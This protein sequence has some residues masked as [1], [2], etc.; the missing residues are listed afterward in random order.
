MLRDERDDGLDLGDVPGQMTHLKYFHEVARCSSIRVAAARL[1]VASSAIS[2]RIQ[3]IEAELGAA[4]FER[5][6][7]GVRLTEMG[8]VYARYARDSLMSLRRVRSELD[9]LR[10]LERGH[11][12]ILTIEGMVAEFLSRLITETR[13]DQP[14]ITFDLTITGADAVIAGIVNGDADIGVAFN[15]RP[16][17][18]VEAVAKWPDPV[19][20]VMAPGHA[21]ARREEVDLATVLAHPVAIAHTSFG[22]RYLLDAA[23][24]ELGLTLEPAL[25]TNSIEALRAFARRGSGTTLLHG[26][27]I[28]REIR[29]GSLIAVPVKAPALSSGSVDICVL[30]GRPLPIAASVF[31]ERLIARRPT[32]GPDGALR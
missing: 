17:P 24:K 12:R 22:V 26:L 13:Q 3:K 23:C 18:D 30:R 10:G 27:A 16:D 31:L 15:S 8:R 19:R 2:R 1:H 14:G 6:P 7:R 29:E 32:A 21:L 28:E 25:T 11:V 20:A 5:H 4:L 9:A